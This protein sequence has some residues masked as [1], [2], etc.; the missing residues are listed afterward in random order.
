MNLLFDIG[1]LYYCKNL[2]PIVSI[3]KHINM[4]TGDICLKKLH[5]LLDLAIDISWDKMTDTLTNP[6]ICKLIVPIEDDE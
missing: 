3:L 5:Q 2:E 4:K 6:F 1:G